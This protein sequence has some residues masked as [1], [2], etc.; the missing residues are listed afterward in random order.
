MLK[1]YLNIKILVSILILNIL[2]NEYTLLIFT[3]DGSI[4]SNNIFL[5]RVFNSLTILL[6]LFFRIIELNIIKIKQILYL[7]LNW[8]S[9]S[10]ITIFSIITVFVVFNYLQVITYKIRDY[11]YKLD[12]SLA[13]IETSSIKNQPQEF[14]KKI[15]P[16]YNNEELI[17]GLF[18][19][20]EI[21]QKKS[22]VTLSEVESILL[23]K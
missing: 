23:D 3:A 1:L 14:L 7:F 5:I 8:Y 16:E 4:S 21:D 12:G 10:A 17:K 11:N 15:Y 20:V 6:P 22:P 9:L 18:Y 19:L 2:I 13:Y